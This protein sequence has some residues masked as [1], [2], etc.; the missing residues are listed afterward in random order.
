MRTKTI[1]GALAA[2][3]AV[4]LIHT[5]ES[6]ASS[7]KEAPFITKNPKVDGTDF[8]MFQSYGD[9]RIGSDNKSTYTTIIANYIPLQDPSGGPNF[10]TFDP[11]AL[12]EIH[13]ENTGDA[14]EDI[15]FQ[16]Q[17]KNALAGGGKGVTLP[18]GNGKNNSIPFPQANVAARTDAEQATPGV[19]KN[20][21]TLANETT[22]L[23]VQESYSIN[24]VRGPRRGT[25]VTPVKNATTGATTFIKPVDYIG[26]QTNGNDAQYK[27]YAD[28]HKYPITLDGCDT[29][30]QVFVGQRKEGFRV[31]LGVIFD[32]ANAPL[33]TILEPKNRAA[34]NTGPFD[35]TY[36][37]NISTIA[38]EIPT[39]CLL[40][41]PAKPIIGGWTTA[42]VRQ[43][44]VI[45]PDA[46]YDKPSKEGGAWAQ[47][48]RL[49]MPLVN[50]VVIG[51]ADKDKFNS[52]EPS[53]DTQFLDYVTQ[54][55]LPIVLGTIFGAANFPDQSTKS[56]D[57][58][59]AIFLTGVP[60]VNA[61][62]S[63]AEMLRLNTSL[64]V[65]G[66]GAQ[67]GG[68]FGPVDPVTGPANKYS[69]LGAAA[70]FNP[71][72]NCKPAGK[73]L[74]DCIAVDTS[75]ANPLAAACDTG[76]FPNGRRP[77]DDVVDISLTAVLGYFVPQAPAG[78]LILHDGILNEE[79]Q[80]DANFPYLKTP[81][82]GDPQ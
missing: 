49:G 70:C 50:E 2:V 12:Y 32:L 55:T 1:I 20:P 37:K 46:T 62:G 82:S 52:S 35:A 31:N 66:T 73:T 75:S 11:E 26:V 6:S 17:F 5:S 41:D 39:K 30:A 57:D 19:A 80:F 10:F 21:I 8:Y 24:L 61:N 16:F 22:A 13:V 78:G 51:I 44:R 9:G 67:T 54:P 23:N 72:V 65:K 68:N 38:L 29:P 25:A 3:A 81:A 60:G 4:S 47:V 33:G 43:A 14:V 76:G 59:V 27:T 79:A 36:N 18:T 77:G 69:G 15:T 71:A 40:S 53:K 48:S 7:H 45:N 64:P 42:S 74:A 34:F 58:L 28:G 56:R 63:T